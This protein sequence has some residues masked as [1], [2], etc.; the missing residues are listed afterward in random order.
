MSS[1]QSDG[2]TFQELLWKNIIPSS[3]K[4]QVI[5]FRV[6]TGLVFLMSFFYLMALIKNFSARTF[7]LVRLDKLGYLSPN[8]RLLMPIFGLFSGTLSLCSIMMTVQDYNRYLRRFTMFSQLLSY[9]FLIYCG[10]L[11]TW[12][13]LSIL[14]VVPVRLTFQDNMLRK[15]MPPSLFNSLIVFL[16]ISV[17]AILLPLGNVMTRDAAN[18]GKET[19]YFISRMRA[20][21]AGVTNFLNGRDHMNVEYTTIPAKINHLIFLWRIVS[22]VCFAYITGVFIAFAY[23][24]IRLHLTL[25]RQV[26]ILAQAR[27]RFARLASSGARSFEK[28]SGSK[29]SDTAYSTIQIRRRWMSLIPRLDAMLWQEPENEDETTEFWDASDF[30]SENDE[31]HRKLRML[32]RCR[33]ASDCQFIF[34]S[35]IF[36][37]F[38]VLSVANTL[39]VF[40]MTTRTSA[41]EVVLF[42]QEWADWTLAVPGSLL[43]FVSCCLAF[44]PQARFEIIRKAPM[45]SFHKPLL[46]RSIL[47]KT[48]LSR[49]FEESDIANLKSYRFFLPSPPSPSVPKPQATNTVIA[50]IRRFQRNAKG[51][52]VCP[53]SPLSPKTQKIP[54]ASGNNNE[55]IWDADMSFGSYYVQEEVYHKPTNLENFPYA[56]G[57]FS[58]KPSDVNIIKALRAQ[59]LQKA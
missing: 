15:G 24:S 18:F 43:A 17:P 36:L 21:A 42:T 2:D 56:D 22:A 38:N 50:S 48:E 39:N 13:I 37:A 1:P 23:A 41:I 4:G 40:G 14:P 8:T 30:Y 31:L 46:R 19:F 11:R 58:R 5:R 54:C 26:H 3:E 25:S 20:Q 27:R 35:L 12:R 10:I 34:A 16:F 51:N 28:D 52:A 45:T 33:R 6:I 7:W 44:G 57:S 53:N 49:S 59:D 29:A 47:S 32:Q 9:V 55:N